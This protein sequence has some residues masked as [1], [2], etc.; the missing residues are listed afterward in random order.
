MKKCISRTIPRYASWAPS[1]QQTS[2]DAQGDC[3]SSACLCARTPQHRTCSSTQVA[4][5]TNVTA[6]DLQYSHSC[7]LHQRGPAAAAAREEVAGLNRSIQSTAKA[8]KS[9]LE[10]LNRDRAAL[11]EP[12]QAKLR[13]LMQ[14]FAATLQ[15]RHWHLSGQRQQLCNTAAT[16]SNV[17]VSS[18]AALKNVKHFAKQATCICQLSQQRFKMS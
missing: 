9:Q 17:T 12:Q 1:R 6:D 14:D 16:A 18:K 10:G 4:L 15:V 5:V 8:I 2:R 13:K 3:R 7:W 11:P